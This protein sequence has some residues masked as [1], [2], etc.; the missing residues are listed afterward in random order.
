MKFEKNPHPNPPP[1]YREREKEL[2]PG[3]KVKRWFYYDC[4]ANCGSS[5]PPSGSVL[6]PKWE[7]GA[8][9]RLRSET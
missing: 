2:A 4:D 5:S 3:A 6:S 9:M 1:E 8:P 7:T